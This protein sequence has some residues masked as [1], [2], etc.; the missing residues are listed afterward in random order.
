V[1]NGFFDSE[2]RIKAPADSPIFLGDVMTGVL[3]LTQAQ[4]DELNQTIKKFVREN[5]S[6]SPDAL[7]FE[8]GLVLYN[9]GDDL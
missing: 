4:A 3:Y 6:P 5:A 9:A 8:Y 1:F 2:R 7:P